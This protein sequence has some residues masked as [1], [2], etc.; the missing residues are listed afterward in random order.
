MNVFGL[1]IWNQSFYFGK[2]KQKNVQKVCDVTAG[3]KMKSLFLCK[4]IKVNLIYSVSSAEALN[5]Y[6]RS[7]LP[8][9]D[10]LRN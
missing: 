10:G 4:I 6:G 9:T 2:N 8:E 3:E 5:V 1:F 7:T